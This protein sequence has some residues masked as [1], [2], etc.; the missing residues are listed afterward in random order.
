[1][2]N[3]IPYY[4]AEYIMAV[5]KFYETGPSVIKLFYTTITKQV[6][7]NKSSLI[8]DTKVNAQ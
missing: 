8:E 3:T 2:T 7:W 4:D 6:S 1:M 5:K